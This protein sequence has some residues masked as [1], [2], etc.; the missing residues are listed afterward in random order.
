MLEKDGHAVVCAAD[1]M[2]AIE[3]LTADSAF[4]LILMDLQMPRMGGFEATE[5]IRK[6]AAGSGSS[7]IPI[8]ALTAH[9]MNGDEERCLEAGMDDYLTKPISRIALRQKLLKWVAAAEAA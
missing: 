7:R 9:A 8:I 3:I 6:S 2:E 4:D 5:L 1:G